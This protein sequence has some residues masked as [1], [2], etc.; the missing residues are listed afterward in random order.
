[1][2]PFRNADNG[3]ERGI[4]RPWLIGLVVLLLFLTATDLSGQPQTNQQAQTLGKEGSPGSKV[5]DEV[6][7]KAS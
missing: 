3:G 2:Q 5:R 6:R 4:S 1:M 7:E